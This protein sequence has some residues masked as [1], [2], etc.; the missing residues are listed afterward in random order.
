MKASY[1]RLAVKASRKSD[2]KRCMHGALVV[3]DNHVISIGFNSMKSHPKAWD[4]KRTHAELNALAKAGR[5]NLTGASIMV[6][7]TSKNG[8]LAY[9]RPC[10]MCLDQLQERGIKDIYYTLTS[11]EIK[12]E[13]LPKWQKY[14]DDNALEDY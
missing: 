1:L 7:R 14:I 11:G 8:D 6:V 12:R 3:K 9:S 13:I 10:E 5:K 4:I 2:H